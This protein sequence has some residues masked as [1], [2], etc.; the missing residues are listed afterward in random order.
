MLTPVLASAP[1][2]ALCAAASAST[3]RH[4]LLHATS[5]ANPELPP[6]EASQPDHLDPRQAAVAFHASYTLSSQQRSSTHSLPIAREATGQRLQLSQV[7]QLPQ[8]LA[9]GASE[10]PNSQDRCPECDTS[11]SLSATLQRLC[12]H[13]EFKISFD[14]VI[15]ELAPNCPLSD[16]TVLEAW[17]LAIDS[18]PQL[19]ARLHPAPFI[20]RP[21]NTN[22]SDARSPFCSLTHSGAAILATARSRSST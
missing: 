1:V 6:S 3:V 8:L 5:V 12:A 16:T 4:A 10:E 9:F 19:S 11:A 2:P 15:V 22:P 7:P 18:V 21:E 17:N 13:P 14:H 20:C